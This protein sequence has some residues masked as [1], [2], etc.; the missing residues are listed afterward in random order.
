MEGQ[1]L[2]SPP[3]EGSLESGHV[4]CVF[5]V[6]AT[7]ADLETRNAEVVSAVRESKTVLLIIV[8]SMLW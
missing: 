6:V 1:K 7:I 3:C 2:D 4:H 8:I 5:K